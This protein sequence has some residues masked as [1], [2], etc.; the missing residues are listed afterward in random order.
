MEYLKGDVKRIR[1]AC[2]ELRAQVQARAL[3]EMRT[4]AKVPVFEAQL[5]LTHDNP[6]V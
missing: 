4:S 1:V 3:E 2:E 5:N 6:K